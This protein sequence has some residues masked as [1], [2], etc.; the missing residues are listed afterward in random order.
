MA[1]NPLTKVKND[2]GD[3]AVQTCATSSQLVFMSPFGSDSIFTKH[4]APTLAGFEPGETAGNSLCGVLDAF[5]QTLPIWKTSSTVTTSTRQMQCFICNDVVNTARSGST[6]DH[7]TEID[8]Q[9]RPA[10]CNQTAVQESVSFYSGGQVLTSQLPQQ[11]G[12][13]PTAVVQ[14]RNMCGPMPVVPAATAG[15]FSVTYSLTPDDPRY[16]G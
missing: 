11:T 16:D 6:S 9:C 2:C 15:S 12:E 8:A 3:G 1:L 5:S 14:D 10:P 13:I 4:D 7:I